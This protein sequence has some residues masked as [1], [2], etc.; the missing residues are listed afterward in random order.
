MDELTAPLPTAS[1]VAPSLRIG[2]LVESMHASQYVHDFVRWAQSHPRIV[3]THLILHPRPKDEAKSRLRGSTRSINTNGPYF[4][5]SDF[6]FDVIESLE[7]SIIKSDKHHSGHLRKF[8]ISSLV[9]NSLTIRSGISDSCL[10]CRFDPADV[11]RIKVLNLDLLLA[12]ETCNLQGEILDA[13]RLGVVAL[14]LGDNRVMRG[15]PAG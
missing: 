4:F 7:G 12:C 8:D 1:G 5:L 3:V 14:R 6:V 10:S 2:L 11:G 13:A 15:G 9:P